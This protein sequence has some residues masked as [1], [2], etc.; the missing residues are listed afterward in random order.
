M[1]YNTNTEFAIYKM[2]TDE[3]EKAMQDGED[4]AYA[5]KFTA[6]TVKEIAKWLEEHKATDEEYSIEIYDVDEDGEFLEGSD[7]N[8]VTGFMNRRTH[9]IRE[10]TGLTQ[11]DFSK[12]YNIPKRTLE[13]WEA[14]SDTARRTA[15]EYV[16]ELLE[17]VV[18]E[19]YLE[20]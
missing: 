17:R 13:A 12:K 2:S 14:T 18:R 6:R 7:F 9:T 10:L 19:D 3:I 20:S 1:T 16:I 11:A 4:Y 15:P 5:K 8:S